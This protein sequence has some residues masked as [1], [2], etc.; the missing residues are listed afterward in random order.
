[1][2]ENKEK[3]K[4]QTTHNQQKNNNTNR[5]KEHK[6]AEADKKNINKNAKYENEMSEHFEKIEKE[7]KTKK[8]LPKDEEEKINKMVFENI[9][10]ADIVM[11]FLYFISLGSLNIETTIFLTDL[12][13]FSVALIAFTIMLF[14]YSYRKENGSICIHGIE[15]LILAIFTLI[16]I[17]LYTIY[18]KSFHMIVASVSFLFAIYY[19]GKSIIIYRKM[20]KQYVDSLNDINEIIKR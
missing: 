9:L 11:I 13:V 5:K 18:F 1:M 4:E 15:C 12:R 16:S 19:V 8:Q 6:D 20:K 10:I 14:E 7:I 3:N 17:Y 2:K